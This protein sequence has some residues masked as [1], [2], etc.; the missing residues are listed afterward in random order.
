MPSH[1]LIMSECPS[2]VAFYHVPSYKACFG[3]ADLCMVRES[4]YIWLSSFWK[5]F[6]L[7]SV[8]LSRIDLLWY[9]GKEEDID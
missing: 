3:T 4:C 1:L 9:L 6:Y 5:K 2:V 7:E 8:V